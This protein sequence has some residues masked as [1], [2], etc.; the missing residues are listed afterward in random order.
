MNLDLKGRVALVTGAAR[1]IGLA[2]VE[3]LAAEGAVIAL[4]DLDK[5]RAAAAAERMR[6]N[7]AACEPFVADVAEEAGADELVRS[8]ADRFGR[9]DILV[10]N[11]GISGRYLGTRV[12]DLPVT[13]WDEM[14]H[15]HMR[16]A[17]LCSRAAAKVMTAADFGRIVNTS[18][19]NFTGGGRPGVAHYAAAKAGI[20]GFTS[21]LAKELGSSGI[22]VNAIAPGYVET[23]LLAAMGSEKRRVI[24]EQNP[25]GRFCKPEEVGAL[26]AFLCS[27]QAAFINGALICLDGGRR[28]FYWGAA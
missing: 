17:F 9:L 22:T 20:A 25:V 18:S 6:A 19:M 3:A 12:V 2:E 8:V 27:A 26:V 7:G 4:N 11:A 5:A 23:E 24:V 1:G 10:N 28:D 13:A 14:I 16:S 21:T 15:V